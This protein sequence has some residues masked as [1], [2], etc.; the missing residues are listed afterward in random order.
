MIN[1][2]NIRIQVTITKE[3]NGVLDSIVKE[4]HRAKLKTSKSALINEAL[5]CYLLATTINETEK[6]EN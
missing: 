4:A 6:G 2:N 1:Q 3:L 5:K